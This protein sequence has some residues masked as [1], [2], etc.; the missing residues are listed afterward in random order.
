MITSKGKNIVAK[1]LIGQ[2]PAYASYIAIG[3]GPKPLSSEDPLEDYSLKQSLDFE[4]FRIPIIS[5]GY[6]SENSVERVVF[7][8]ELPSENR[9]EIS[10]IGVYSAGSNPSSVG[11]DSRILYSFGANEQWEYHTAAESVQVPV[12]FGYGPLDPVSNLGNIE[13][14]G[15]PVF[16]TTPDNRIFSNPARVSRYE[17]TRFLNE[18]VAIAGNDSSLKIKTATVTG[19]VGSAGFATYT[20]EAG[21]SFVVGQTVDISGIT[22]TAYNVAG[23]TITEKTSTTFK[24]ANTSTSPYVSGGKVKDSHIVIENGSNHIHLTGVSLDFSKNAPTDEVRLA[25]SVVSK[26]ALSG[27]PQNAKVILEFASSDDPASSQFAR[28]EVDVDDTSFVAGVAP[29]EKNFATNRYF[30]VSKEL[31]ELYKTPS[32]TWSSVDVVK[33]FGCVLVD[34]LPSS[35]HFIFL[36]AIRLENISTVDPLYGLTAYSKV[37]TQEAKTIVK[38]ANT[39]NFVEFR[40][41]LGLD[42]G[43]VVA[44]S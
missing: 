38:T 17:A 24:I 31:Q 35:D 6:V 40:F 14:S 1:Y 19:V 22:P 28:L 25:F 3:C 10:E 33:I 32:F 23:G 43:D 34:G 27:S 30:V 2:A 13:Y 26:N 12:A 4:M 29:E 44:E 9:H 15:S 11:N 8:A 20:I 21:H 5:R 39:S 41:A 7:T 36:D 16:R 42:L 18:T 37:R